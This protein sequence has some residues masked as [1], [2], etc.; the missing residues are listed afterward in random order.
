MINNNERKYKNCLR[1]GKPLVKIG[2][3]RSNGADHID[4]SNRKY[5][6]KCW[7]ILYG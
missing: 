2:S 1:C 6:K 3:R 4:W 5:H 7:R